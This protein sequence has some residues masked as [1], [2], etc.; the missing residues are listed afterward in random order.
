MENPSATLVFLVENHGTLVEKGV[1]L[2]SVWNGS[3]VEEASVSK[4][5]WEI[6][7]ALEDNSKDGRYI[8]TVPKHGYRFVAVV[9]VTN[10]DDGSN[11][12]E[13]DEKPNFP[14]EAAG[15]EDLQPNPGTV[16]DEQTNGSRVKRRRIWLLA[17][18]VLVIGLVVTSVWYSSHDQSEKQIPI[19]SAQFSL[20]KLSSDGKVGTAAISPDGRLVVYA[21][22]AGGL[23][24]LW[25]RDLDSSASVQIIPPADNLYFQLAIS[26]DGRD[27]YFVRRERSPAAGRQGDIFR[28]PIYGGVPTKIISGVQASISLSK[29][30]M[31]ISFF[32]CPFRDDEYCSLWIADSDGAN[33]K[34]LVSRPS[35]IRIGSNRI[36]PDGTKIA[37]GAGQS[38]NWA[39]EFGLSEVDIQSGVEREITPEKFFNIK[40]LAWLPD[41]RGLLLTAKKYPDNYF[42]IWQVSADTGEIKALTSDSEDYSS[43]TLSADATLLVATRIRPDFHLN[44][45]RTD[46]P[47][48]A[49]FVL[50]EASTATFTPTGS[51]ILSSEMSGNQ[52][53][54]MM[55]AD[56]T[57]RRQLTNDPALDVNALVSPDNRFVFFTSNRTGEAQVWRMS[58]DGS[59]QIQ[60]TQDEGGF[61]QFVSP[62]QK[63]LYY[64]AARRR[65]LMRIPLDGGKAEMV[66]AKRSFHFNFSP[67]GSLVAFAEKGDERSVISIVSLPNGERVKAFD[68]PNDKPAILHLAWAP[69]GKS[70]YYVWPNDEND[71][72]I[73]WQQDLAGGSPLKIADLGSAELRETKTFTIS[74][75]GKAFAAVQGSWKHDAVLIRGLHQ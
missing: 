71:R 44:V 70:L 6:R 21:D 47:E 17:V 65:V 28:M 58:P 15:A 60:I 42:R 54:W 39:N 62:D 33:E 11:L 24:S 1:L 30:G 29:D 59:E 45:Y 57:E 8:Q 10:G 64:T 36:S 26:P 32:R 66:L 50:A 31:R 52:D 63:W 69:D 61:P 3:F 41:Q 51:I 25:L 46:G 12:A 67:D 9:A 74:P 18:A 23:E 40:D 4:C 49:P 38:R 48:P 73:L 56:G 53:I 37:F 35:M 2:D 20:E 5:I 55:K 43:L 68:L 16:S 19:L 75:D 27:I 34:K 22:G 13:F 7:A 14:T 72:Y